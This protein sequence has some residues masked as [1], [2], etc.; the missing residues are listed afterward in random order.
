MEYDLFISKASKTCINFRNSLKLC[1]G[2]RHFKWLV[3]RLTC[4]YWPTKQTLHTR[5]ITYVMTEGKDCRC[6]KFRHFS[7]HKRRPGL[8]KSKFTDLNKSLLITE[9]NKTTKITFKILENFI[10]Q[11]YITF[12]SKLFGLRDVHKKVSF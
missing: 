3:V 10:E 2:D 8:P 1:K 11:F 9:V 12:G 4:T 5:L 6:G 7:S